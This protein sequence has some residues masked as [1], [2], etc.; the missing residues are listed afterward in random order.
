MKKLCKPKKNNT[1]KLF[2]CS[3]GIAGV[4]ICC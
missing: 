2:V 1:V 3:E 4:V